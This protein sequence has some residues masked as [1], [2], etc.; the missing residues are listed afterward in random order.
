MWP[1][2]LFDFNKHLQLIPDL[3][4][5]VTAHIVYFCAYTRSEIFQK[6]PGN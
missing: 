6:T 2:Y 3:V 1:C 5:V 4:S